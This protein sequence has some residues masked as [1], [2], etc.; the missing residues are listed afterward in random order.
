MATNNNNVAYMKE[1]LR[2]AMIFEKYVYIWSQSMNEANGYVRDVIYEYDILEQQRQAGY[3][4]EYEPIDRI[5][6]KRA[7]KEEKRKNLCLIQC[8]V[9]LLLFYVFSLYLC[10]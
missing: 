4:A 5:A 2:Q 3:N 1:Y 7:Y 8:L 6:Y 9:L 10:S